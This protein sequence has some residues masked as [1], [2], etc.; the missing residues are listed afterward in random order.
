M[1]EIP[2][3]RFT[4]TIYTCEAGSYLLKRKQITGSFQYEIW[5][6]GELK[7]TTSD[8][9]QFLTLAGPIVKKHGF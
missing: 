8:Y 1:P 9:S 7:N 3:K 2:W 4:E 6:E 5:H